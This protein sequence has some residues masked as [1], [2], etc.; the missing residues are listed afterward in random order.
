MRFILYV[1]M[2]LLVLPLVLRRPFFGLCVYYVVSLLQ[3]KLL[4][5]RPD[6]QDAMLVGVP[7]VVGAIAIGARRVQLV[8]DIDPG[9]G[10]IRR[11]LTT[12]TRTPLFEPSWMALAL[13]ALIAYVAVN[14]LVVPYPLATNAY[15]FKS[16]C[17]VLLVTILLTG[18]VSDAYRFRILFIVVALSTAFWAIKGGFKVIL[19]GP[20]Q[21]YGK[22]YD[23]N[24]FALTSV[25]VLPMVFYIGLTLKQARWRILFLVFSALMCLGIIGS[26]SRAGFVAFGV[27]LFFM[28]WNSRYRLRA[29]GAVCVVAFATLALSGGEILERV[30]SIVTY[31]SDKSAVSRFYTWH[32]ARTLFASNPL[33][34]V[35]FANFEIAKDRFFG[36][37]KAAHNI[38]LA[39]LSE[40]GL[41]G[42]PLWLIII[43]GTIFTSY[44]LTRRATKW[45]GDLRWVYYCAR[46][47]LLGMIAFCV[48]G[49]FH[50]EEYLELM[51]TLVGLNMALHAVVRR[52][53]YHRRLLTHVQPAGAP[54][55][56]ANRPP[57]IRPARDPYRDILLDRPISIGRLARGL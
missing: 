46:G 17:K 56:P 52:E 10:R 11:V 50:N 21:V 24:L 2:L 43:F 38:Y 34:G 5:W 31:R 57:P 44:R 29:I 47:L 19:L 32:V 40:L 33:V 20:H 35:G 14:R 7:L 27:V 25:M 23:N 22:S 26:R 12:I 48:H 28:A 37:R 55:E 6:F 45:P 41:I 13:V 4:C 9:A 1:T 15:Q 18:L 39:N 16:L 3:P 53:L 51:F 49:M 8:P 36:G 42:H 54:A 30:E